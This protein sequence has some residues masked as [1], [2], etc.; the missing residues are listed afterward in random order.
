VKFKLEVVQYAQEHGNRALGRKFDVDETDIRQLSGE[1]EKVEGISKKKCAILGKK[2][3]Y[4]HVEAELYQY[5][6]NTWKNRFAVSMEMLQVGKE[7]QYIR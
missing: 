5:V 1:K 2:C 4:A 7:T 3:K 6:M